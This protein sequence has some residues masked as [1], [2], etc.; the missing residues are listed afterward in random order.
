[1]TAH[2]VTYEVMQANADGSPAQLLDAEKRI[3]VI[4]RAFLDTP[5]PAA[6]AEV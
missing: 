2:T 4:P 5:A 3:V 6:S 1:M